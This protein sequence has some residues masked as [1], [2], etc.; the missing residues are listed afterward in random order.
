MGWRDYKLQTPIDKID[1]IDKTPSKIG[2]V[3]IV[4]IVDR[5][6]TTEMPMQE[7]MIEMVQTTCNRII[8]EYRKRGI[9]SYKLTPEI[10]QAENEITR[11]YRAVM[12]GKD[13]IEAYKSACDNWLKA[14]ISTVE[15]EAH[16]GT[17]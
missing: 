2:F 3:D 10:K 4:D 5:V 17:L 15:N 16:R 6:C 7:V 9:A 13:K 12:D 11:I 14:A 8:E 1:K